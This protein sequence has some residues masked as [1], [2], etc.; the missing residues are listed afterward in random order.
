MGMANQDQGAG[1]DYWAA[2]QRQARRIGTSKRKS[3]SVSAWARLCKKAIT[4][5]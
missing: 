4:G 3:R 5:A 1:K 2:A